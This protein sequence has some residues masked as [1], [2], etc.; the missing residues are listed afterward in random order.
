MQIVTSQVSDVTVI[1]LAGSLDAA[2]IADFD[3]EWKAALDGGA[4]K[5]V[6][7]LGGIEYISSAGLRGILMLSKTARA[8]NVRVIFS[9][10]RSMVADMFKLSGFMNILRTEPDTASAVRELS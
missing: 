5:L 3:A 2:S 8:G 6:V 7:D 9:D 1:T 10:L 4:T